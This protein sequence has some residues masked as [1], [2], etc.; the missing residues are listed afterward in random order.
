MRENDDQVSENGSGRNPVTHLGRQMKRDR[1]SHGW[2]L[3]D[4]AAR[5]GVRSIGVLSQVENGVR[6]M[7]ERLAVKCDEV[8][9][10]RRGW[11]VSEY[12]ESQSWIPAGLRN[13]SEYEDRA[14]V[15]RVWSPGNVDG[16]LQ[17]ADYARA[18]LQTLPGVAEEVIRARLASR[19]ARQQRILYRDHAPTA[20]FVVDELSLYRMAG[21]PEVMAA[22]MRHLASV[23]QLPHVTMQML[24]AVA[25]PASS[26]ELIVTENAAYVEHLTGG[27]VYADAET[28]TGLLRLFTTIHAESNKASETLAAIE[29]MAELWAG[30]SPLIQT[31]KAVR[32]LKSRQPKS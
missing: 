31:L 15:L 9:L 14:T 32:A 5:I 29:G 24:P 3:R 17:T 20:W 21:S 23:A 18:Q 16:L 19:M 8:F 28:V 11:Y 27:L 30:G 13:W 10:E 25:N 4:F 2:S 7:S 12:E 6:P 26:S 1:Q 22:Q